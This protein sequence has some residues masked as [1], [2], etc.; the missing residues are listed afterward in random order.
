MNEQSVPI[1]NNEFIAEEFDDEIL[2][3]AVNGS[4][5]VYLNN[6]AHLVWQL[7]GKD[8][9]VEEIIILLKRMYPD[10]QNAIEADVSSALQSLV[11]IGAITFDT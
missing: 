4:K 9:T 5:A 10:Q 3:Y 1:I 8:Q 2:I 11:A 6:T 7:C